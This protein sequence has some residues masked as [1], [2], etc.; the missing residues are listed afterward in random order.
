MTGSSGIGP[1]I[2]DKLN[3]LGITTVA[4]IAALGAEDIARIDEQRSFKGRDEREQRVG[5]ARELVGG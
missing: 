4:R 2:A 3:G 1:A 5:Q